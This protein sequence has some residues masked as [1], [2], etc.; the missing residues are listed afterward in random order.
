MVQR[1]PLEA[2]SKLNVLP[3]GELIFEIG[4][5]V[6]SLGGLRCLHRVRLQRRSPGW[7]WVEERA[8]GK[9]SGQRQGRTDA[10]RHKQA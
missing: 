8:G 10:N 7:A 5:V 3:Q 9:G 2:G 1:S 4:V 6:P